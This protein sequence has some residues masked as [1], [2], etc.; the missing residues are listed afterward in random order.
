MTAKEIK[1]A[2]EKQLPVILRKPN[3][4]EIL[5][6]YIIEIVFRPL[7]SGRWQCSAILPDPNNNSLIRAWCGHISLPE[8]VFLP[9]DE[10]GAV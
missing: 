2:C 8:G 7:S 3:E 4:K 9:E 1:I 10:E 5:C 6:D